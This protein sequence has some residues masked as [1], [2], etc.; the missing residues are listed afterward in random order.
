MARAE[1]LFLARLDEAVSPYSRIVS[2][3]S[4]RSSPI[5]LRRLRSTSAASC[6]RSRRTPTRPP[7]PEN[8][9]RTPRAAR[10][11][12]GSRRRGG[13]S[14]IRSS[15]EECAGAR[16][17][18]GSRRS[19][20]AARARAV[21]AA[22]GARSRTAAAASSTANGRLSSLL[23]TASTVASGS[24]SR[25]TARARST[26]SVAASAGS[27]AGRAH[28][29]PRP[30]CAAAPGSSRAREGPAAVGQEFRDRRSSVEEVFEVVEEQ[31]SSRPRRKPPRSS[32]APTA[33][34]ISMGTRSGS[35]SGPRATQKT[36]S[37]T[38][39]TNSAATWSASRVLPVPPG[40][41]IVT[42]VDAERSTSPATSRSRPRS[43]LAAT[44]R[45]V[46]SSVR[47]GGKSPSPSW[48][49]R[50]ASSGPSAGARRGHGAPVGGEKVARRA[51]RTIWPPCAAAAMR[52]ARCTSMPTY[53]SW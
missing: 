21:R 42:S 3:M 20:E 34:A 19:G 11:D 41:V 5:G 28:T 29:R 9:R 48:K 17:H 24:I 8:F 32:G 1:S 39:Q 35:V 52:A 38:V 26:K 6:S 44:G 15:R 10:V 25:P 27:R 7:R 33:C 40:P 50:S 12:A 36:P 53:P 47:S 51:G 45:F 37:A 30:R 31:H 4:R 23:Q 49:T 43:G 22:P 13:R 18:R 46:A 14:S 16:A 2:S